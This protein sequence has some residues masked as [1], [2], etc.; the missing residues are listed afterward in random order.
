MVLVAMLFI[1]VLFIAMLFIVMV[2]VAMLFVLVPVRILAELDGGHGA[3]GLKDGDSVSLCRLDDIEHPFLKVSTIDHQNISVGH[4][5]DLLRRC[6]EVVRIS[7]NRHDRHHVDLIAR[8]ILDHITKNVRGYCHGWQVGARC[9]VGFAP[10]ARGDQRDRGQCNTQ[11]SAPAPAVRRPRSSIG[12]TFVTSVTFVT[13]VNIDNHSHFPTLDFVGRY[14]NL[15]ENQFHYSQT[16]F[17]DSHS[18]TVFPDLRRNRARS[19][20]HR[21]P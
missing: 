14:A 1:L 11:H 16:V 15:N 19:H 12:A 5:H 3:D 4:L 18:Q 10:T 9:N 6:L 13:V 7:A 20:H 21:E 8:Q 17:P 2:L